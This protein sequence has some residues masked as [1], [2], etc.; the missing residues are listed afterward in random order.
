MLGS[1]SSRD[2]AEARWDASALCCH[3]PSE[4]L[5]LTLPDSADWQ[6]APLDSLPGGVLFC[7][8]DP[9]A[10]L[11][12]MLIAHPVAYDVDISRYTPEAASA[13]VSAITRQPTDTASVTYAPPIIS[14]DTY[15]GGR[16]TVRF[17]AGVEAAGSPGAI[18]SGCIFS[19]EGH[20]LALVC[21]EPADAPSEIRALAAQVLDGLSFTH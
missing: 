20:L 5:T 3:I 16:R 7:A 21:L 10:G 11:C 15:P 17:S 1:C 14:H 4:G 9:A 18:Y 12:V 19:A 2:A 8:A 6:V 13:V